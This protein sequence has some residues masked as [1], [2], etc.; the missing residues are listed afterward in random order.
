MNRYAEVLGNTLPRVRDEVGRAAERSGREPESVRLVAVT[1]AHPDEVVD[2]AV[3]AGLTDLGEN[4][5][6]GLVARLEA[7]AS[8]EAWSGVRWHMIGHV[9]SRKAGTVAELADWVHSVDSLKLARRLSSG[10]VAADREVPVL[11]QANTSGED[12]KGGFAVE[13]AVEAVHEVCE[14]PGLRVEGLMTMAPF[15]DDESVLRSAFAALREARDQCRGFAG[16]GAGELS[17][18][19]SNDYQIAIEEGSTMVRLGT[20]L[21]GRRPT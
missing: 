6:Q 17:M 21:F 13:E 10:A 20:V 4:R 3:A 1:K 15:V 11:V 8:R 7:G 12:S 16:F 18:G 19:M 2:A 9:Q 14:L 5:V